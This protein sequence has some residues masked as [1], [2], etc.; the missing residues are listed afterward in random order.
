MNLPHKALVGMLLTAILTAAW[1]PASPLS[2]Q[3]Q[4]QP[5][6]CHEHSG[7]APVSDHR[8]CLTGHDVAALQTSHVQRPSGQAGFLSLDVATSSFSLA[9]RWSSSECFLC[10]CVGDPPRF[11]PLQLAPLR[12]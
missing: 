10:D 9:A 11:E 8:C 12:V 5:V 3:V 7:S 4:N 1:M 6:G 2:A